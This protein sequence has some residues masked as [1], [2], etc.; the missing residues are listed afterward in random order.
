M[1]DERYRGDGYYY[2]TE[3]NSF[4]TA[5]KGHIT[6]AGAVLCLAEGEGRNAVWL[7]RQ[8][9]AVTAVEQSA[10]GLAKGRQLAA[11]YQ[12]EVNWCQADLNHFEMGEA[13]WDG[14]IS[15]FAHL[16][17]Q[18]RQQVHQRVVTAL[19]P[20]GAMVLEAYNPAQLNYATGGP[21]DPQWLM[22]CERLRDELPGL[23]FELLHQLEREVIEGVGHTGLAAVVQMVARK[24]LD[25]G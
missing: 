11:Q 21:R 8:G 12:V 13:Q 24:P 1:W 20:G 14:I 25:G 15:I 16:P 5:S 7:A 6:P 17:P 3:P 18:L 19:K 22:T 4:L 10:Y 2:G 9:F 23:H